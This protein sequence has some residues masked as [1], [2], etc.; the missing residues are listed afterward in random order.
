MVGSDER[1][2]EERR[3][4]IAEILADIAGHAQSVSKERCPYKNKAGFCTAQFRCRNQQ[5]GPDVT[6]PL[7]CGHD[8][9]FDYRTAWETRPDTYDKTR[10]KLRRIREEAELRRKN[11][12]PRQDRE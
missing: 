2:Y 9:K 4:R 3:Q 6:S 1:D 8:G 12:A 7:I 5:P 11:S 10:E